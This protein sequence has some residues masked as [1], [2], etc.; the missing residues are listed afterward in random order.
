MYNKNLV[1]DYPGWGG[2]HVGDTWRKTLLM[3]ALLKSPTTIMAVSRL[4]FSCPFIISNSLS[5][6]E[7]LFAC[8]GI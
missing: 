8:G 3:L 2:L 6:A 4:S 7:D 1:F 5:R